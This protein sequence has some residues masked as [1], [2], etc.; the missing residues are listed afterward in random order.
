MIMITAVSLLFIGLMVTL[1]GGEPRLYIV[2]QRGP[3]NLA[4]KIYPTF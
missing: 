3:T 1:K 4:I 2:S